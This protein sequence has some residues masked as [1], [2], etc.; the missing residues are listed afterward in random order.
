METPTWRANPDWARQLGYSVTQLEALSRAAV[1]LEEAEQYH[2]AQIG[3]FAT[4][5]ADQ[6]PPSR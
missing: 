2:S 5:T 6:S 1:T 3:T 4:T